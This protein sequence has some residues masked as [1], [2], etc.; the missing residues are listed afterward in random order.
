[1]KLHCLCACILDERIIKTLQ[2]ES[3]STALKPTAH[4]IRD[5][6]E[7]KRVTET[8]TERGEA[9]CQMAAI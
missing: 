4:E 8:E 1:M 3:Y 2:L 9:W 5:G 7:R 6:R